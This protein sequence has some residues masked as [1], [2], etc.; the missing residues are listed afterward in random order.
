VASEGLI[1]PGMAVVVP[2]PTCSSEVFTASRCSGGIY[3]SDDAGQDWLHV[4]HYFHYVMGIH[5]DPNDPQTVWAVSDDSLLLSEDGGTTWAD[6]YVK[7]HFHGFAVDPDDSNTLLMGTVGS[8]EWGDTSMHV[9]RSTDHGK[10][11]VDS[12]GGLPLSQSSAHTLLYWPNNT[13]VVLLGTYKGG[14]PSHTNG[15]GIG[16][17]RSEDSGNTWSL[18][19]L[20]LKNVAWLEPVGNTVIAATEAGLYRSNDE[21]QSWTRLDGPDGFFLSVAFRGQTGLGL[22]QSGKVW[23]SDD[24]GDTW[25][26][27]DQDLPANPTTWLAQVGLSADAKVAWATVFDHGVYRIGL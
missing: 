5:F 17:F 3:R 7:Y 8:G 14:D 27:L 25:R 9:L 11:W 23:R 6:A 15:D 12:S 13:K 24:G 10:S 1:D 22:A 20:P 18:V 19:N 4:D 26:E 21:G 16:L 2:H